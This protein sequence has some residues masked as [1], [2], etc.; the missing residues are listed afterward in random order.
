MSVAFM[1]GDNKAIGEDTTLTCDGKSLVAVK[2]TVDVTKIT[3]KY[4]PPES[5]TRQKATGSSKWY[6]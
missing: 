1:Q 2:A 6:F 4:L 3:R 5:K